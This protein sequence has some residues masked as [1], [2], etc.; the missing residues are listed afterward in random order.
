MDKMLMILNC[1]HTEMKA[2]IGQIIFLLS[3][4]RYKQEEEGNIRN[5]SN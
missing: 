1:H 3:Y 5:A 2:F 4:N